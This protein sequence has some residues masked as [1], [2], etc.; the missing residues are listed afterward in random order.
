MPP[1]SPAGSLR[2]DT[3]VRL[4]WLAVAGQT[5]AVLVVAF[6]LGFPI[7]RSALCFALIGLSARPQSRPPR[8]AIPATLRLADGRRRLL[9]AYDVLQLGGLLFLTG[10]LD[11]PFAILLLVPVIV[12]AT[13]LA[14]RADDPPRRPRH[15][16]RER[17]RRRPLAAALVSGE[18]Q[19]PL[20]LDLRRRR[21][22]GAGLG[23]HLHR[24]LCLPRRRGGAAARQG[25]QRHRDGARPRAASLG[26]RRPRRR[27]RP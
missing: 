19:L 25:A 8:S 17:P 2:L 22:G 26:A 20:P 23:L 18:T 24:R 11:N 9:L 3:L 14:P 12:S 6:G 27:R 21:L 1:I 10:G 13:T 5:A 7:C 15:R 16:R 4:R